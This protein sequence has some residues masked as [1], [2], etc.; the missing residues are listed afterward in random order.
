MSFRKIEVKIA[1]RQHTSEFNEDDLKEI[2]AKISV[3]HND[4]C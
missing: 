4:E 2:C 3:K 1:N